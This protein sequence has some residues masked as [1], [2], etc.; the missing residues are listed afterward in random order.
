M[1]EAGGQIL[2]AAVERARTTEVDVQSTAVLG[3]PAAVLCDAAD[4]AQLLVLGRRSHGIL[5]SVA[6]AC[7][8]HAACPV[9]VLPST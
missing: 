8:A 3:S 2:G 1:V 5:G 4:E 6:E 7:A 9:L